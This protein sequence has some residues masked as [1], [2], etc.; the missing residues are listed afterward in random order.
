MVDA[1]RCDGIA[2]HGDT[3]KH[4][5]LFASCRRP[6]H[7]GRLVS[8]PAALVVKGPPVGALEWGAAPV[9]RQLLLVPAVSGC[10]PDFGAT[11]PIGREIDES[12][13][14]RPARLVVVSGVERDP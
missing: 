4:H 12:P 13:V 3:R 7:K 5:A 8:R 14:V 9:A 11:S 1:P 2:E 10:A 6:G